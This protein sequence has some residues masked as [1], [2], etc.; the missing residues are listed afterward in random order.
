MEL[1]LFS[2]ILTNK[3]DCITTISKYIADKRYASKR[4]DIHTHTESELR[5]FTAMNEYQ[6]VLIL[7]FI[8][9]Q[10]VL[11]HFFGKWN[12]KPRADQILITDGD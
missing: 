2:K 10:D 9:Q 8:S 12:G 4:A 7:H 6:N 1:A 5:E 3:L 11:K